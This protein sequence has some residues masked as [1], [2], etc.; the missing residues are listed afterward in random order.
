MFILSLDPKFSPKIL[1]KV[2]KLLK[3]NEKL[4]YKKIHVN[5]ALKY[6]IWYPKNV[7]SKPVWSSLVSGYLTQNMH[8]KPQAALLHIH[9]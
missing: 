2:A 4:Q 9:Q 5:Q 6:H 1:V 8:T 7:T 3:E